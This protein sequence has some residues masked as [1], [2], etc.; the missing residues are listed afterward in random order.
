MVRALRI[1][2][3]L[4]LAISL[5][6]V[7]GCS[8]D[9]ESDAETPE[10]TA[11]IDPP[12]IGEAGVLRVGID[13]SYPPFGGVDKETQAGID[14][15]VASVMASELGLEL[16]IVDVTVDDAASELESGDVDLVFGVPFN[17]KN[18]TTLRFAGAYMTGAPV[19]FTV[20][21]A[22]V[23]RA[24]LGSMSIAAQQG[25]EAFWLLEHEYG[26]GFASA[27]PSLREAFDALVDEEAE[28]VA[29][30]ALV[31]A[32]IARDYENAAFSLQLAD[33][34]PIGVVVGAEAQDLETEIRA[35]LDIMHA[36][37]V[38]DTIRSKWVGDLPELALP[39]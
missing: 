9:S 2:L 21:G 10:L 33:G 4:A 13:L 28:A 38:L 29:G 27:Y 1:T 15:D 37:G 30:D 34:V 20:D 39:E 22:P 11:L 7:V 8:S 32:Y 3:V 24:E 6:T 31:G 23:T 5:A 14:V 17:E 16:E 18:A 19:V 12:V 25:S 26:A 35:V 36:D